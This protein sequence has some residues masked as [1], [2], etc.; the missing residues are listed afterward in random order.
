M[1]G[2][3][4]GCVCVRCRTDAAT[5][6]CEAC[7]IGAN[8]LA[9]PWPQHL[10]LQDSDSMSIYRVLARTVASR[11]MPVF[12]FVALLLPAIGV[13][14]LPEPLPTPNL[15]LWTN[16]GVKAIAR[17]PDGSIVFGGDFLAVNGVPRGH[18]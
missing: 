18:L 8:K 16:G 6:D 14:Q 15:K 1:A 12:L 10:L 7:D 17:A 5:L 2:V 11:V 4:T 3:V 9:A 13:A